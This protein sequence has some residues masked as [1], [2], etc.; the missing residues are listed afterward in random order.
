MKK[1]LASFILGLGLLTLGNLSLAQTPAP[2]AAA[3]APAEAAAPAA[4]APAAAAS[5]AAPAAAPAPAPKVDSG[6]T[7]WMLTSTLLVILMT[8]PGLA[9]FYGGLGRSKNMLSVLV[10]V[11]VIFSLI[12][13]LWAIY[14]YSLAFSG[15][16]K[17]FGG[18]D[19]IFLK[20]VTQETFGALT[21]IPEYV[22]FAFQ[23]TFAAIT[24]AL[25]VGSFAE[26]IKFSAVLLFSVLWFTFSY[27]PMA[28]IVW[29]GGLLGADGALDFAGGTVVHINAGVA[30][31]VGAYMVG[32]RIGYGKEAMAP[33]SLT[34]TMVGASLL[35]VGW[36]GFNAGSA[37]AAN[38][39]AGLAFVNTV[40]A[41]AAATL[42]WISGEALHKG[43]ASMLGAASGAVAGLVAVT[44][45]AGFVG[46]M[47]SIVMGLIAGVVCL[48]GVGGL[49]RLLNVDDAFDVFG[50]HGVGGILGA[51]LTGVFAAQGLGGTGGL[52]P[53]TFA[54]GAQVWIQVKSVL[55]TIVWS[56][57]VAFIAYKIAD[58]LVGLRVAEEAEREGLDITSHGE[59]AYNR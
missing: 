10:Q 36:F 57:V 20:G 13:L 4:A 11:F 3:S 48:W 42:S 2:E 9:L 32:K 26:R 23:G 53:D 35:W 47:G 54:M 22:F 18:F 6:D 12:S 33:H 51:I 1:L 15:E 29:G 58:L 44:P 19:K 56:G 5:E 21:T 27:V 40:L 16:G 49:K 30:G 52:T 8:I 55:F 50:V 45:A 24:V 17:F 39:N 7:A 41:T 43:K 38:A 14:G 31:L 37:G 59:T 34:L 25:I 28:H 46:P